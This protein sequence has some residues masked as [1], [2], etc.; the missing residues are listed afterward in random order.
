M[1]VY[2]REG[3]TIVFWHSRKTFAPY[4]EAQDLRR[5]R[6]CNMLEF[7]S[8]YIQKGYIFSV[9]FKYPCFEYHLKILIWHTIIA[10]YKDKKLR[11]ENLGLV[12]SWRR[13]VILSW[14]RTQKQTRQTRSFAPFWK[15]L[16]PIKKWHYKLWFP[17]DSSELQDHHLTG[18]VTCVTELANNQW[19][20]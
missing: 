16:Q 12:N 10:A 3:T 17:V 1:L 18:V 7:I 20:S 2:T 15:Y 6:K 5:L 19:K 9:T 4:V 14:W 13:A 11:N 8:L